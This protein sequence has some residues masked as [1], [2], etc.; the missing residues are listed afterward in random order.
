MSYGGS[1]GGGYG[2]G[3]YGGGGGG[4]G[5]GGGG[6]GAH[7]LTPFEKNFYAEDKRVTA[8]SDR[9]IE[10]F[11]KVKEMKVQG[12]NVPRPVT[13]FEEVGFPDYILSTIHAQGFP[14]PTPI[15]CQ[16]WPMALS[17]RDVVAIA[18]TGSG[19]TISFAL[20]AM[21]HINAQPLLTHGDG[22]IA[23]ILAPTRELAVQIQQE[24]TK[25]GSNS[26]IRNTAIYGGAP[27]G[28]QIHTKDELRRITYLVMDEADRMLDMGFEPQIRKIVGQIRPDRQTL[29]FSATWPKDVQKLANDF[30]K[31]FIQ[32]N[33]GSME[34]TANHNI[35]Q[36]VEVCSDFE[37]RAKLIKHLDQISQ[38]NAKVLIFVGTK[39][40]ADDITKYLRQDGWPALAIHGDKEQRERDWVLGEF[41]AGR[42]PILI[43]TDVAS[44]GL[45]VKD[46][47]YVINYDF[48]NNCEDYIHRIGRTGRA[49]MKGTSYTYFTT[50]NAKSARE[51]ISILREA[52]ANVPPQLEEMSMFG[53]SGGRSRYGGGGRGR[54]GGGG[55]GG[56]RYGGHDNGYGGKTNDRW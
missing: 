21:L 24:C 28:P 42:S 13:S 3:G 30:L 11:R 52:K 35:Q 14:A 1:Y 4:W 34:L 5:G 54:G 18:Q 33:I 41:K 26:R 40:V 8:R 17:G 23:L 50:D 29:M 47:G 49:G 36:I 43:A 37:K 2:G 12:R 53:G 6:G 31:D 48:P 25:F 32:V 44:R 46:V 39:R 22:P 56:G 45:D 20:P 9:E 27:K 15:Q 16:A 7:K 10:E 19:K 38:E 55:G 51:L